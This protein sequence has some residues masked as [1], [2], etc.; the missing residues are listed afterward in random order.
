[1]N[2]SDY[3]TDRIVLETDAMVA[4]MRQ[5]DHR[6]E[7]RFHL[8][9]HLFELILTPKNNTTNLVD[10][11]L[12]VINDAIV[13]AVQNLQRLY[14]NDFRR[15]I[16]STIIDES[17]EHGLNSGNFDIR[18]PADAIA[19][20]M[21][22]M[23]ENFIQS[24][25]YLEIN[26]S[27]KVQFKVLSVEHYEHNMMNN[28]NFRPH[29]VSG[30]DSTK[31][32]SFIVNP[33]TFCSLHNLPC[34]ENLCFVIS[35]IIGL[36][37]IECEELNNFTKFV[38]FRK[39]LSHRYK[40]HRK[41]ASKE[42]HSQ[43]DNIAQFCDKA[44]FQ[45]IDY[46]IPLLSK[47]YGIQVHIFE[48]SQNFT[49]RQSYPI[50]I[51]YKLKQMHLC[52]FGKSHL[53]Y[54]NNLN[55]LFAKN[56]NFFCFACHKTFTRK[57]GFRHRCKNHDTCFA[58]LR[59]LLK[60]NYYVNYETSNYFCDS[61]KQFITCI[62]CRKTC[63][64]EICYRSHLSVCEK[65]IFFPCCNTFSYICSQFPTKLQVKSSHKCE[66]ICFN[67]GLPLPKQRSEHI[68]KLSKL[69]VSPNQSKIGYFYFVSEKHSSHQC[70][71]CNIKTCGKHSVKDTLEPALL[72]LLFPSSELEDSYQ[73]VIFSKYTENIDS[74]FS[75]IKSRKPPLRIP[76]ASPKKKI[77]ISMPVLSKLRT[78]CISKLSV[79]DRF[80]LHIITNFI[81]GT[82][83]CCC[84]PSG[85]SMIYILKMFV[86]NG[87]SPSV[88]HHHNQIRLISL[89]ALN[90]RF[91]N[92]INFLP[93]D[94][95]SH[96]IIFPYKLV[97]LQSIR[98]NA[99]PRIEDLLEVSDEEEVI[100][101][102]RY[103][104]ANLGSDWNLSSQLQL[105][106]LSVLK[107]LLDKSTTFIFDC[108]NFQLLA[109]KLYEAESP[110]IHPYSETTTKVSYF[111]RLFHFFKLQ[112]CN[113]Y[114][115]NYEQTGI[116]FKSSRPEY[117]FTSYLKHQ[118]PTHVIIDAF[119]PFGQR[120]YRHLIPDAIDCTTNIAYMFHG[121]YFHRHMCHD[122]KFTL[123][124]SKM[125]E[126]NF[127]EKKR[128]FMSE[129][130]SFERIIVIW[131]C[132]WREKKRSDPAVSQFLSTLPPRPMKRAKPRDC[133]KYEECRHSLR[134]GQYVCGWVCTCDFQCRE[135]RA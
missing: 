64:S 62:A 86:E 60:D 59:F 10:S 61:A 81:S 78:T 112:H 38:T 108:M 23:L 85:A 88:S 91:I 54:I 121:C 77:Q 21:L 92:L 70:Q 124:E 52:M 114:S 32:P 65:G 7:T 97:N 56:K 75:V 42:L 8:S 107:W 79:L 96:D 132:E 22:E 131:E 128:K 25:D 125:Y 53:T 119:H 126:H 72:G 98:S 120:R 1:M 18:T 11:H 2:P 37:R 67:C 105:H 100:I 117:E 66:K 63:S 101:R 83:F 58:C 95:W 45:N 48:E 51:D 82:V 116:P 69:K 111:F 74:N 93:K 122:T 33:P 127:E 129:N 76:T 28:P 50:L 44:R 30:S 14:N 134:K 110:F 49:L 5:I 123:E 68:C 9:D 41:S 24:N 87:L 36:I 57:V 104:I 26:N 27:F 43:L 35:F 13:R 31:F 90:I 19:G 99:R 102:K 115:I 130:S 109:Q 118:N 113:L 29:I 94:S 73:P 15:Q 106:I 71:N 80:L 12:Q 34:F 55:Q 84:D 39:N 6:R 47:R 4:T 103:F 133:R 46:M 89:T 40:I 20:V 135:L 16:Y 3:R 17:I